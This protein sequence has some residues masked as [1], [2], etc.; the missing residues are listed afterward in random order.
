MRL[1]SKAKKGDYPDYAEMYMKWLPDDGK[2]LEHFW[3]N[4]QDNKMFIC[5]LPEPV[6][7]QRYQSGKWSIKEILMHIIKDERPRPWCI[8]LRVMNN[9]ISFY[10]GALSERLVFPITNA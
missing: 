4:F 10:R 9:I 1:I 3:I 5:S 8:I 7:Y 2:V 6:L